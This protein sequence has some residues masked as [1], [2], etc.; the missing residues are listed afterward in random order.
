MNTKAF[1]LIEL[2]VVIAILAVLAVAVTLILNPAELIRQGR[3]STRLSDLA[4]IEKA[5]GLYQVDQPGAWLGTSSIAYVS[6]PDSNSDCSS[7]STSSLPSL[8]TGW[9]YR[10][11]PSASSTAVDGT[12]WIPIDLTQASFSSPLARLPIDPV[13]SATSSLYYTYYAGSYELT[14]NVESVRYLTEEA[15]DGGELSTMY[16]RGTHF[17]LAVAATAGDWITIPGD[18]TYN[19]SDFKVMKYEA[20]CVSE[21]GEPFFSPTYGGYNVYDDNTTACTSANSRTIAA[22]AKGYSIVYLSHTDAKSYCQSIGA[23]LITNDE[24]MTIAR[25]AEQVASN[26]TNG[27]VGDGCLFRG[28]SGDA[29]CGYNGPDP[30]SGVSRNE[31][32]S[33][34]LSNGEEIYDL[35]GNVWEH[36]KRD[37]S[38]TL[39]TYAEQPDTA[40]PSGTWSWNELTDISDWDGFTSN[41]VEPSNT[42]WNSSQGMGK[43]YH[44]D[45]CTTGTGRV[46]LRGGCWALWG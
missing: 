12:G 20:K 41:M 30:D 16:E 33:F 21:A 1:T 32:A 19:T 36:V 27:S 2:L 4:T 23:H 22:I 24:W 44:C 28:N 40:T 8:P 43:M 10:C 3:D 7:Y 14:A 39:T 31:R 13:N 34:T 45:G 18:S 29:T 15:D 6:L 9:S 35:V 25:N 42:N 26:W 5:I 38:D 37:S 17:N 11:V 46:F